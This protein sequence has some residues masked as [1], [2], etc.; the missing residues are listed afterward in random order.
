ML[1][2]SEGIHL[3]TVRVCNV[4]LINIYGV[5]VLSTVLAATEAVVACAT[6]FSI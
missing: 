2:V 6:F 3:F 4:K 1:T 5:R